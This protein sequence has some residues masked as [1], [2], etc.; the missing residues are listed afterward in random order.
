MMNGRSALSRASAGATGSPGCLTE[1][2][3]TAPCRREDLQQLMVR[4]QGA[5]DRAAA[6][7]IAELSPGLFSF[8]VGPAVTRPYA[9]DLLQ[10]S[11]LRIHKARHTYRPGA[12]VLPWIYA[13]ARQTRVDGYRRLKRTTSFQEREL[14]SLPDKT[15]RTDISDSS[16][17]LWKALARLP[18]SQQEVVLMLK[19]TG[20]SLEEVA[21]ATGSTVAAVKQKAHRGYK[22]LRSMIVSTTQLL[23]SKVSRP[24]GESR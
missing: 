19:V 3:D 13:I 6:Q 14:D 1:S 15:S 20:M 5:D 4:Y 21:S 24:Y 18:E 10:E 9:E 12:P 23:G 2:G 8:L 7:L 11:W 16:V 22:T 17:D